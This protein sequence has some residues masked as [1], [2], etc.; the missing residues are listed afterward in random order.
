MS[1]L[2][3]DIPVYKW[4]CLNW[5]NSSN[6]NNI[7]EDTEIVYEAE[8]NDVLQLIVD[9]T[10]EQIYKDIADFETAKHNFEIFFSKSRNVG[11]IFSSMFVAWTWI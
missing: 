10:E 4:K 2:L 7:L 11:K 6:D 1:N 5:F 8:L 9:E 3:Q